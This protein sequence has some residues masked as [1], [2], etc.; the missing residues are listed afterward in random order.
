M[1]SR[2]AL[3]D[4]VRPGIEILSFE[5]VALRSPRRH[6]EPRRPAVSFT[7]PGYELVQR[8]RRTYDLA[9][10][11]YRT[12][13]PRMQSLVVHRVDVTATRVIEQL[14]LNH[15]D[16]NPLD[17]EY[18]LPFTLHVAWSWPGL[19]M[20][21]SVAEVS[22]TKCALRLSLRSRRR[23]RYP[24]RYFH[25]AHAALYDLEVGLTR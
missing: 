10:G 11:A 12:A 19:P 21:L 6:Q 9:I 15:A 3:L 2:A 5:S 4:E 22:S 18:R 24:K 17:H 25:A 14:Q 8:L 7:P 16:Y 23:L 13:D 1:G 20:W